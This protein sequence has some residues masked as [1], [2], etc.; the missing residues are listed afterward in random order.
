MSR[1]V[2]NISVKVFLCKHM[3]LLLSGRY[4]GVGVLGH[5][6]NTFTW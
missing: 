2:E 6:V 4:S 3:F 5:M 1:A